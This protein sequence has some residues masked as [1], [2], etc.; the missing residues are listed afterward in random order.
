MKL[1]GLS[2]LILILLGCNTVSPEEKAKQKADSIR[3]HYA[4]LPEAEKR[5]F[6]KELV[7][8]PEQFEQG[9]HLRFEDFFKLYYPYD[10]SALKN[11]GKFLA[12]ACYRANEELINPKKLNKKQWF[13]MMV[14]PTFESPFTITLEKQED[15][16]YTLTY[17]QVEDQTTFSYNSEYIDTT[18]CV[19]F[20]SM[21]NKKN[22]LSIK[23]DNPGCGFLHPI[24]FICEEI[25]N[26]KY[27]KVDVALPWINKCA[28]NNEYY[29]I[30][31][32]LKLL[33]ESKVYP[34]VKK[35][36]PPDNADWDNSYELIEKII[37]TPR[38]TTT[39]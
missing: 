27:N 6:F 25:T 21:L 31:D 39:E 17:S 2:L 19:A 37:N 38:D 13:R 1:T 10:S 33:R 22:F 20:F 34:E 18:E 32:F 24:V 26:G 28:S 5:Q 12:E 15:G 3:L 30:M 7:K 4:L 29:I 36:Y 14:Q 23:S 35:A 16:Y 9:K 8:G 11:Y